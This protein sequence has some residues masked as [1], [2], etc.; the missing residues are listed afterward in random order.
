M[1]GICDLKK[2]WPNEAIEFARRQFTRE[3]RLQASAEYIRSNFKISDDLRAEMQ[4]DE[5]DYVWP[6]NGRVGSGW[7]GGQ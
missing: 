3:G 7:A 2:Q 4:S 6:R 5:N 1:A